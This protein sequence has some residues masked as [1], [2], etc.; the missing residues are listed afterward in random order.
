MSHSRSK[1][2]RK[3]NPVPGIVLS[4][5]LLVAAGIFLCLL[6]L[7]HMLTN[8]YLFV[9]AGACLI[10]VLIT[11]YLTRNF[12]KRIPFVFGS[13]WFLL[14]IGIFSVGSIYLYRTQAALQAIAGTET[15]IS[16]V[17]VYVRI[18]DPAQTLSD[19]SGYSFGILSTLDREN[20]DTVV[21]RINEQLGV[22]IQTAEF[23]GLTQL[24]D[25]LRNHQVDAL[26][27]N[28]AYL[29]LY[30]EFDGY[31][32][33]P[34][35]IR[36][37][38]TESI[39]TAVQNNELTS[40]TVQD[41][42]DN[43]V[44]NIYISG[45]DTRESTLPSR[46]RSDV[47]I[48]ASI[49]TQTHQVLLISTPRDYYVPLSISNGVPDKLTHAGI[50]GVQVSMDT[51]SMLYEVPIDYYFRVNF[52]GFV[53]I[54]DALG[55]IDVYSDYTFDSGNVSGYHFNE[56]WNSVNG[57]EAL[58]FCRERYAFAS[59]DR[60]RGKNQMAVIQGVLNKATSPAILS[61]YTSVLDSAA[62]CMETNVPYDTIAEIVRDQLAGGGS[63][64][65]V[66]YSV[67]GTGDS[68]VPYSMSSS[69]YVMIPDTSTVDQAKSLLAQVAAG[70]TLQQ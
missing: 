7:T 20:T 21:S 8:T 45:S 55:G 23:D 49:N 47:N 4:L 42:N 56:G 22:T 51:L 27:L 12:R 24:A 64:N 26:I 48:L 68:Q 63:W 29:D 39:E 9:A 41:L 2:S 32:E 34:S 31:T 15:E 44:L 11:F 38:S 1:K 69:V 6:Y 62:G 28:D 19:A 16:N 60:Q 35:Q 17:S 3:K 10:A 46:S 61:N 43:P 30:E 5:L 57:E 40:T 66:S 36:A 58:T 52:N 33:F 54:I 13:L 53:D 70:E 59:G 67:D 50:Y 25:G 65:V 14:C 18:D 37:L